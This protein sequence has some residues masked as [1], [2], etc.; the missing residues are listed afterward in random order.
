M[1][2]TERMYKD[3]QP[4]TVKQMKYFLKN[5]APAPQ[6]DMFTAFYALN[7][8]FEKQRKLVEQLMKSKEPYQK[9]MIPATGGDLLAHGMKGKQVGKI[10]QFLL[11]TVI[12]N[13]TLNRHSVL[14]EI[15]QKAK[16]VV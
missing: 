1:L 3:L 15:A 16:R 9:N 12:E 4:T 11:D 6:E 13:P 8:S 5:G 14:I 2:Q 10:L 7:V